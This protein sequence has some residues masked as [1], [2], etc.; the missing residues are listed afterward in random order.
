MAEA[1][2]SLAWRLVGRRSGLRGRLRGKLLLG[3]ASRAADGATEEGR[4][5]LAEAE[6]LAA[7]GR[8]FRPGRCGRILAAGAFN[9]ARLRRLTAS[10]L[11]LAVLARLPMHAH[12][13][14]LARLVR[15]AERAL[16]LALEAL[17]AMLGSLTAIT[18][19]TILTVMLALMPLA[20]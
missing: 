8:S 5:I 16:A 18:L 14:G 20:A 9:G 12:L 4:L 10:V 15:L 17:P 19:E 13:T 6:T 2:T 11:R 3:V 7:A 1:A